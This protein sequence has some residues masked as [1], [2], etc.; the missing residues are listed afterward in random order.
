MRV[1]YQAFEHEHGYNI[2]CYKRIKHDHTGK[3]MIL[4]MYSLSLDMVPGITHFGYNSCPSLTTPYN[5]ITYTSHYV[6]FMR[7]PQ[8]NALI[9][10]QVISPTSIASIISS[11][12][13]HVIDLPP[14]DLLV[15]RPH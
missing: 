8:S 11:S 6:L 3:T 15:T 7:S 12:L 14:S 5:H 2:A 13:L 1:L 10:N 9:C 4:D